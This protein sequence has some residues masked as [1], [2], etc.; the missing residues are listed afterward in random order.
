M[1]QIEK[2]IILTLEGVKDRNNNH[3]AA[4]V[5]STSSDGTST[6]P[7]TIPWYLRGSMGN[8]QKGTEV[9]FASFDDASGM[10][11]SRLDGNWNGEMEEKQLNITGDV[12]VF[13]YI[14]ADSV[15][16]DGEVIE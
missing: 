8:L 4:R 14:D 11:L 5:Q 7:L 12:N 3:T 2:G 1:G 9:V 6:L 15:R 10:I 16:S 13:G